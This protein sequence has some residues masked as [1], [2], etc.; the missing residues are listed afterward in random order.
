MVGGIYLK[1]EQ[2][3]GGLQKFIYNHLSDFIN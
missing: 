3:R 1:Y 2:F